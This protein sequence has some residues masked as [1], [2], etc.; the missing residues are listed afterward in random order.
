MTRSADTLLDWRDRYIQTRALS[1]NAA[2]QMKR[3]VALFVEWSGQVP[4]VREIS[5]GLLSAWIE[6]LEESHAPRSRKNHRANILAIL[7]FAADDNACAE[8]R[9]RRV[10]RV[11]VPPPDPRAWSDD[12]LAALIDAAS[13][14]SGFCRYRPRISR[15]TYL[16][17]LT[18]AAY[19]TGLRKG[20]LFQLRQGWIAQDGAIR[21]RQHKTSEP[22]LCAVTAHVRELLASIPYDTPLRW[23]GHNDDYYGLWHEACDAAGIPRGC[24][25][26]IRRTAATVVWEERPEAVQR[27]LGHRTPTMWLHYVDQRRHAKAILPR[28]IARISE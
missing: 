27:F 23:T 9:A 10:R 18:G 12:Q 22:H 16:L 21:M 14:L 20:D 25:Q 2:Y 7:R 11:K 19:D 5:E 17:A 3:S 13:A 6:R 28:R 4:C 26:Q 15:A 1:R 8:P 24:T